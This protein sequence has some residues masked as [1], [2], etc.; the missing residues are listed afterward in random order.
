MFLGN[1]LKKVNSKLAHLRISSGNFK[2]VVEVDEDEQT[3]QDKWKGLAFDTLDDQ[4]D[5]TP[6]KGMVD[7]LFQAPMGLTFKSSNKYLSQLILQQ[8]DAIDLYS[9]MEERQIVICL[10]VLEEIGDWPSN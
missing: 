5:I 8:V 7:S 2:V 10:L 3:L 4:Y 1:S 9:S 6:G